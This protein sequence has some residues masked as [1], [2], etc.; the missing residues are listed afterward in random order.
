[1]VRQRR[2]RMAAPG[3]GG[4]WRS[5]QPRGARH[6]LA[7]HGFA[8]SGRGGATTCAINVARS[9]SAVLMVTVCPDLMPAAATRTGHFYFALTAPDSRKGVCTASVGSLLER[10]R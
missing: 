1:M 9:D 10:H 7:Y 3:G 8:A 2:S 6:E 5:T 4:R